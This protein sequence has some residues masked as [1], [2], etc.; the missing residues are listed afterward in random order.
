[1]KTVNI[2][3]QLK[4]SLFRLDVIA[5]CVIRTCM[6]VCFVQPNVC[7]QKCW[8]IGGATQLA[9][10]NAFEPGLPPGDGG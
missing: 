5:M 1:M 9:G 7:T 8:V 3:T 2:T 6:C 4:I 10:G